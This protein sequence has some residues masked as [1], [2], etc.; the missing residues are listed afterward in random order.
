LAI[1]FSASAAQTNS[2]VEEC[3]VVHAMKLVFAF[4]MLCKPQLWQQN[5]DA[6][7]SANMC[8]A[9]TQVLSLHLKR[10]QAE[11]SKSRI[12]LTDS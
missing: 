12:G 9:S 8:Q 4:K 2:Q 6:G 7:G 5:A 10:Q 3:A 11:G 1:W